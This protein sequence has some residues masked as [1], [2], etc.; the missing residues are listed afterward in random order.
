MPLQ[1]TALYAALLG[2]VGLVL[3]NLVGWQRGKAK[4][5]L[6]DGNI[7]P[8]IEANRR[9]MNWVE[10]IPFILLLIAIAELNGGA[11]IWLHVMGAALLISRLIHPFG[12]SA[13]KMM[14]WQRMVGAGGTLIVGLAAIVTVLWQLIAR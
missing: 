7:K 11:K 8:L 6:N 4:I 10:N 14:T 3:W 1:V 13:D 5:S 9:H 12:I 2:I